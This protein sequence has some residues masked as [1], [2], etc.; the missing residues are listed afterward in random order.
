MNEIKVF[1]PSDF[2]ALSV[3]NHIY[4]ACLREFSQQWGTKDDRDFIHTKPFHVC[5]LTD[6]EFKK[7]EGCANE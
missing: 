3:R 5:V 6:A 1:F 2:T 4:Y 7:L